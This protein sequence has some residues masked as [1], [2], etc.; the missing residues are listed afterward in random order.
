[1][2]IGE[3]I[4]RT[5]MTTCR[6]EVDGITSGAKCM[7]PSSIMHETTYIRLLRKY[8]RW[9]DIARV[10]SHFFLPKIDRCAYISHFVD[11]R[12][13][14][15]HVGVWVKYLCILG[16]LRFPVN[17]SSNN[18]FLIPLSYYWILLS[19]WLHHHHPP[20]SLPFLLVN[21]PKNGNQSLRCVRIHQQQYIELVWLIGLVKALLK[22]PHRL[23]LLLQRGIEFLAVSLHY[24]WP[25]WLR[26]DPLWNNCW[27][28]SM[29]PP[30]SQSTY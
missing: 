4:A 6:I 29:D 15:S 19:V 7:H 11:K 21:T 17:H 20:Q 16:R 22:K 9:V 23:G 8:D 26:R 24:M 30:P 10:R 13:Y 25:S 1:M 27:L 12:A 5:F 18:S 2:G 3:P 28:F 14:I